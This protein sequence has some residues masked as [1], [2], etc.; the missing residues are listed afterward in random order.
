MAVFLLFLLLFV[1]DGHGSD[2]PIIP[3]GKEHLHRRKC[4]VAIC[5]IFR[6]ESPFLKEWIEYHLL[7]GVS[8]FYLYNNLSQDNYQEVLRPYVETGVVELFDVPFDSY[9]YDDGAKMHN[10]AQVHCYNHAI[11]LATH[12]N[13]WLAVIDV[14]EFICPMKENSLID[15]LEQYTYAGALAVYWHIYGTSQVWDLLPGELLLEKLLLREPTNPRPLFKTI[16]QPKGALCLDPHYCS[17][18]GKP[19]VTTE[20]RRFSHTP[21]F[22]EPPVDILKIN[23]YTFRTESYYYNFKKARRERW[24]DRPDPQQVQELLDHSN[25]VYDPIMLRFIPQLKKRMAK[26][27]QRIER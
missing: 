3:V 17:V 22:L 24:G 21:N 16:V 5:A 11:G 13:K 27:A 26:A 4:P 2:I 8:H 23:H 9:Q 19:T 14:D 6:D 7:V 15:I 18:S 10:L 20:H 12:W 25:A 1:T